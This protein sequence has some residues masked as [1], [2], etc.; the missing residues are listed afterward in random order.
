MRS[1]LVAVLV[2]ITAAVLLVHDVPLAAHLRGVERDRIVTGLQR[3]AF[4]LGGL[5]EEVLESGTPAGSDLQS[6][7]DAYRADQGARVL[8]TDRNGRA[9]LISDEESAAG[10]DYSTRPEIADAIAGR[11]VTGERASRTLGTDLLFVAVPVRSGALIVGA[12]RLTFPK[13]VVD[14]RVGTRVRGLAVVAAISLLVALVAAVVLATTVT[15]PLRRVRDATERLAAGDLEVRAP[16]ADGPPEVTALA[17]A[18]NTM[19]SRLTGLLR[20]QRAFAGDASHQLRTPLTALR[21]R[22]DQAAELVDTDPATARARIEAAGAETERLQHLVEQLLM[23][24]RTEGRVADRVVVDLAAVAAERAAVWGPLA[25]EQ[26]VRITCDAAGP[27]PALVVPDAAEQ[28][29]DNYLDNALAVAP[30][31]SAV[32]I[33][34]R[35][36]GAQAALRVLDRGPGLDAD[37]RAR[38]FDRFWRG[39]S[40]TEGGSGLGLAIVSQLARASGGDAALL[41]R[42]G[43]GLIAEVTFVAATTVRSAPVTTPT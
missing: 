10:A 23:L 16:V 32:E 30:P 41:E 14:E 33:A 34:V 4:T 25:D 18:F 3:D 1:R 19:A 17:V 20:A 35:R 40:P 39:T 5:V 43:G 21:L 37:Q 31:G 13:D 12:V 38:A 26:G 6:L 7:V 29:L 27:V 2:G 28:V 42:P 11:A 36:Q 8:V 22:L 15:R 9:V 24:A